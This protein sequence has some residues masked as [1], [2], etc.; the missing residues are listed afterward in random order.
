VIIKVSAISV[1]FHPSPVNPPAFYLNST[2]LPT[3]DSYKYLG[4][5]IT[6]TITIAI[7]IA[8]AIA[9]GK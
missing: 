8:I 5:I 4:R 7:T 6:I 9:H 1:F 3:T 2:L